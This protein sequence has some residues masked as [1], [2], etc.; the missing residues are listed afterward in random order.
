[1]MARQII[2][3]FPLITGLSRSAS[4]CFVRF[5]LGGRQTRM[6]ARQIVAEFPLIT[7]L[8][9]WERGLSELAAAACRCCS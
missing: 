2:A 5:R 7:G 9:W 8:S 1:M 3:E 4:F 6:V